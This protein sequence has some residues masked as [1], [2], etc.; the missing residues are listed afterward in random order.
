MSQETITEILAI[1]KEAERI[2]QDAQSRV[3]HVIEEARKTSS[4]LHDE[5]VAQAR[6]KAEQIKVEGQEEASA[7]RMR[8]VAQAEAEV[9]DL[10]MVAAQHFSLAERYVLERVAGSG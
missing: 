1:E 3:S 5:M 4:S 6:Q 9:R 8:I 7:E 10:E 2:Y